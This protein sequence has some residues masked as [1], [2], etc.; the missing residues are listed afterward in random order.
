VNVAHKILDMTIVACSSTKWCMACV[1][2]SIECG[3]AEAMGKRGM[4]YPLEV[5]VDLL[6]P[7]ILELTEL[8]SML[9]T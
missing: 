2:A 7:W 4:P 1:R 6:L 3:L 9:P 5:A 8:S